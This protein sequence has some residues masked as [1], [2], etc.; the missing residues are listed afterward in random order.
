VTLATDGDEV[1]RAVGGAAATDRPFDLVLM[2][3]V[4]VRARAMRSNRGIAADAAFS[5]TRR[6][7]QA[8]MN[9]DVALRELQAT[10]C[11][12]RVAAVTANATP[13][14]VKRYLKQGFAGVL[15]KPF[16]QAQLHALLAGLLPPPQ[17]A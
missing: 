2:D 8:R 4:M 10:G 16:S 9:G 11:A 14:D 6:T 15:A 1:V 3:L 7:A 5:N 13:E 12:I 17:D